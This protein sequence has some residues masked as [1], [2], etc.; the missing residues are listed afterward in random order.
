CLGG[1]TPT[2]LDPN[3]LHRLLGIV[4]QW[5]NLAPGHEFSVEANPGT[6]TREKVAVLAEKGVNR[7]SLGAQS[8]QSQ[9]LRVLERDHKPQDVPPAVE[10]IKRD[11]DQI[12]LDLIFGV[13]G[14]TAADW[15]ADLQ[16]ALLF[17]P[18]HVSTY[19]LTY[20]KGTRL[21]KQRQHGEIRPL[22]EDTELALYTKAIDV[23]ESAGFEHYEISNFALPGRRCR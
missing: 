18:D 3:Q 8:F 17:R 13:P 10:W 22:D 6:L 11:I 20:E 12:S 4:F 2:C 1:G 16:R 14:Q 7:V 5:L 23:L 21:W 19:G 9:L 15:E